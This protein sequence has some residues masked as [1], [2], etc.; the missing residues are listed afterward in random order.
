MRVFIVGATGVLGR[1]VL[2]R[3]AAHGDTVVALVRSIDRAAP[4]AG[5]GVELIEGDLLSETAERLQTI[6]TG[7]DVAA[8][9]ATALRPGSPGLGA[10]NTNAALR[11]DGSR[12]L[13]GAVLSAGVPRYVQQSIALGYVDGGD[14]WL[15]EST[16]FHRPDDP[17]S[18]AQPVVKM[19]GMVRELDSSN[20]AWLILRGGSFVGPGTRQD[21]VLA[22]LRDASL[23]VPGD[24]NNWVSFVHV[25]DYADAVVAAIHSSVTGVILNVTDEPIRN[26]E[27]LDRLAALLGLPS[28]P[29]DAALPRPRSYR[30]TSALARES[31]GWAPVKGIW[32]QAAA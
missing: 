26:G 6:L 23:R 24:G 29:R 8:H 16:A 11:I 5:P 20:V 2:P 1:A 12:R 32:P 25:E 30:C 15:D 27:Y 31:L 22:S 21:E 4:I 9:L 7:C 10:T 13:L 28:P 3:L 19:E 18:A 14:K 17:G